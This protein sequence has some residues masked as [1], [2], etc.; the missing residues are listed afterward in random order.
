MK[1]QLEF[2]NSDNGNI[3]VQLEK[4]S[5]IPGG[6]DDPWENMHYEW[7]QQDSLLLLQKYFSVDDNKIWFMPGMHVIVYL[8]EGQKVFLDK[9]VDELIDRDELDST[10]VKPVYNEELVMTGKGLQVLEN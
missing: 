7:Y 5:S 9:D 4:I 2:R 8:P 1:P 3:H 10:F 6:D